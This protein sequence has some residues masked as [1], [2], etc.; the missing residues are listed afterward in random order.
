MIEHYNGADIIEIEN[1]YTVDGCLFGFKT[2]DSC[3]E[4]IDGVN[5]N[6]KTTEFRNGKFVNRLS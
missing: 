3:K 5:Q 4:W 6:A 2:I 1:G